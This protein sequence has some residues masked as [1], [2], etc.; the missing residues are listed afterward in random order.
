[1]LGKMLAEYNDIQ[2]K[3]IKRGKLH[4]AALYI[5]SAMDLKLNLRYSIKS[6][7]PCYFYPFGCNFRF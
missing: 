1:M 7:V 3:V 6:V 4:A 2:G 5:C